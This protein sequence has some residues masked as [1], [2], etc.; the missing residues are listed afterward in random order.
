MCR[1][2]R[3]RTDSMAKKITRKPAIKPKRKSR[4]LAP[5]TCSA[6]DVDLW[7]K[8]QALYDVP[9]AKAAFREFKRLRSA[10]EW[11]LGMGKDG[12]RPRMDG[13]GRYWWRT[14]LRMRAFGKPNV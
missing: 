12:F 1:E 13:E 2:R 5:A 11:A 10:I 9:A 14:E 4:S 3:K 8:T 7:L 6:S